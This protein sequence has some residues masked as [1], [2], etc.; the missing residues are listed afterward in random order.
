M[1]INLMKILRCFPPMKPHISGRCDCPSWA[2]TRQGLIGLVMCGWVA[3]STSSARNPDGPPPPE[4]GPIPSRAPSTGSII[5]EKNE[6]D[7]QE[8]GTVADSLQRR[9][10][11]RFGNVTVD[12][13][14]SNVSLSSMSAAA[15]DTVEVLKAVT[16]DVDAD[17]LGGSVSV[18]S[19][20]AF[21]QT[22]RTVQGR[23]VYTFDSEIDDF[24]AE[25]TFTFGNSFGSENQW[26]ALLTVRGEHD[27]G[28][29]DN[30]K[31]EWTDLDAS[32]GEFRVIDRLGLGQWRDRDREIELTGVLD[33][34]LNE[35]LS[36]FLRGNYQTEESRAYNPR[37][38]LRLGEGSFVEA[39]ARGATIEGA[40]VKRNLMAFESSETEWSTAMGGFFVSENVDGDFRLFS[41]SSDY[42][43]P[44]FFTIDFEQTGVDLTYDLTDRDFPTFEQING[45]SLY[46]PARFTFDE[47]GS[48]VFSHRNSDLI[49][50][51]NVK[52]R[53]GLG[54][55]ETGFWKVGAK[56]RLRDVDQRSDNLLHDGFE[57]DYRQ[58]HV[59]GPYRDDSFLDGRYRL[60]PATGWPEAT[61][62]RDTHID[63][64]I[65]NERRS[66]ESSDPGTYDARERVSAGYGMGVFE[67]GP[68]R[69][70]AGLRY[71]QTNI[72]YTGREVIIDEDGQYESTRIRTGSNSY[73]NPF[74]GLHGRYRLGD[75]FTL[76]G[77]W[78]ETIDRPDYRDLV[79]YRQVDREYREVS[80][81]NP[82]LK[83]ALFTNLDLALDVKVSE[84]GLLSLEV[85]TRNVRDFF[86]RQESIIPDG[87][88]A[89]YKLDRLENGPTASIS[90]LELT[91]AQS[92]GIVH[93][94]LAPF[95]FNLNYLRRET[96]IEYPS[97]PGQSFPLADLPDEELT[98]AV[99]FEKAWFFGQV[100]VTRKSDWLIQV[101]DIPAEDKYS[102]GKTRIN[103]D[104][105]YEVISG[106]KL[107]A[108]LHNITGEPRM[109]H[110]NAVPGYPHYL[111]TDS[112]EATLGVRWD[113]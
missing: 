67:T 29:S 7:L 79:P 30:R 11:L 98:L 104:S 66:R 65:L 76:I 70:L 106:L 58:I 101:G 97:R 23:L 100:E 56:T 96:S 9:P 111:R 17:S 109:R 80:E 20:P 107:I 37:F 85:F 86:Y 81:G 32:G 2:M 15:V 44:D 64:F 48:E 73:G 62:Y 51:L 8:D 63:R 1:V 105:T 5:S 41:K 82:D 19:K 103:F 74:P 83:P 4:E 13:E 90:G 110:Y 84:S 38:E 43:E 54:R 88:Y 33:H 40:R 108:E 91:W 53:H 27:P 36:F 102:S 22:R 50:T 77:S 99:S 71:E 93:R 89:G 55:P 47:M 92:L 10:D 69:L 39:S 3:T 45:D 26:G 34:R 72:S 16:P 59:L 61:E 25:G 57:G 35:H 68:L 14:K 46:D 31:I 42:R 113:L 49:G 95:A 24:D 28:G 18:R 12:G 52:V 94:S 60:D 21:D 112:W 78:T 6:V 75:R 87:P